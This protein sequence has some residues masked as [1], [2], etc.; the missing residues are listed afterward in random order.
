MKLY[1][2]DEQLPSVLKILQLFLCNTKHIRFF[3][4]IP[5]S[6]IQNLAHK[7]IK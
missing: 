6:E 2:L 4:L 5:N 3:I 7:K 1:F